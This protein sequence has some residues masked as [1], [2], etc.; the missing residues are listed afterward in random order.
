MG[1]SL[2]VL[3]AFELWEDL[4]EVLLDLYD[5]AILLW[6]SGV[7]LE[8]NTPHFS[9]IIGQLVWLLVLVASEVK[10]DIGQVDE[11]ASDVVEL[12]MVGVQGLQEEVYAL[13]A[14]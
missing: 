7:E 12:G 8:A 5:L 4:F 3:S 10:L 14:S 2:E 11:F 13:V 9:E 1:V 6:L